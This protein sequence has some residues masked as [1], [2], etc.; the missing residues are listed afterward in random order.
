MLLDRPSR[1]AGRFYPRDPQIC[2]KMIEGLLGGKTVQRGV[3]TKQNTLLLEQLN[4]ERKPVFGVIV[5]HAGWKYSGSTAA[6]GLAEIAAFRPETVVIFGA[7]HV[8]DLNSASLW[9]QGRWETPFGF[10]SVDEEFGKQAAAGCRHLMVDPEIHA[11]EHSIEVELP[12]LHHWL[13]SVRILPVMVRP[14]PWAEEVGRACAAAAEKLNRRTAFV[15]STDL[16]HYG[17]S[18]GF[19]PQGRGEEGFRWAKEVNDRRFIQLLKEM[20]AAAVVPEVAVHQNAC[21]AGAVAATIAA[22]RAMGASHYQ[23]LRHTTSAEQA[24]EFEPNPVDSVGYEAGIF[25]A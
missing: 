23:E 21:G 7:I 18:F 1:F 15:A 12:F 6:I 8:R 9:P 11:N 14:G 17:P 5:P 13:N 3:E 2:R 10:L 16:T 25:T 24:I 19:E 20:N 22:A 4:P